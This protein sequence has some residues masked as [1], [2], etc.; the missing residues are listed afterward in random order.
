MNL[1]LHKV[2]SLSVA[3]SFFFIK[4]SLLSWVLV[5]LYYNNQTLV[6]DG[7]KHCYITSVIIGTFPQLRALV[8]WG[9]VLYL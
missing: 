8:L 5:N 1:K 6:F 9:T 7:Y 4:C 2:T 3:F